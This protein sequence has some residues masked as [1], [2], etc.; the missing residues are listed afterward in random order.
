MCICASL[1]RCGY[2]EALSYNFGDGGLQKAAPQFY[3]APSPY[4]GKTATS[5]ARVSTVSASK[6]VAYEEP[7]YIKEDSGYGGAG[8][9]GKAESIDYYVSLYKYTLNIVCSSVVVQHLGLYR[10]SNNANL[11]NIQLWLWQTSMYR[12]IYQWI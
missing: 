8:S 11:I 9:Y 6:P 2:E 1:V 5:Y 7:S 10:S 4:S 12:F 3:V